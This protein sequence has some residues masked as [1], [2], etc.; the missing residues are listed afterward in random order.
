MSWKR[1]DFH[2]RWTYPA[3]AARAHGDQAPL[4]KVDEGEDDPALAC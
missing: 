1:A 2:A 3:N 4:E